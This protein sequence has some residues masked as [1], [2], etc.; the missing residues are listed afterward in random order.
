MR[1]EEGGADGEV[2]NLLGDYKGGPHFSDNDYEDGQVPVRLQACAG[3][4]W[5]EAGIDKKA[6]FQGCAADLRRGE[7]GGR[8][9]E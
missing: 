7:G 6:R 2:Q 5:R 3:I 4:L 1:G 9:G 8:L